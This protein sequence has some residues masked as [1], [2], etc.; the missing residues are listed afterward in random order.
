MIRTFTKGLV[1]GAL[2]AALA[3]ALIG[4]A[5]PAAADGLQVSLDAKG[6]NRPSGG[7]GGGGGGGGGGGTVTPAYYDWMAANVE[8]AWALGALGSGVTITVVDDY[9]S[10]DVFEGRLVSADVLL[11][12]HGQWTS[13]QAGLVAPGATVVQRDWT[14]G[15]PVKL[16]GGFNVINLSYGVLATAGLNVNNLLWS[17][18]DASIIAAAENGDALISK[19]AGNTWGL[20]VGEAFT[21]NGALVQD[22]LALDLIGAQSALFVGALEWNPDGAGPEGMASYSTIAGTDA[23]VQAQFLVV[24]VEGGRLLGDEFANYGIACGSTEGTCL[25]GTSFAAPIVSGYGALVAS[26]FTSATPTQVA[27]QLLGTTDRDTLVDIGPA[28]WGPEDMAVYGQGEA[29]VFRA[30]APNSLN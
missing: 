7:D 28:G 2:G 11:Q 22:Y 20:A 15:G 21:S 4:L 9:N 25:Y 12:T 16:G 10:G 13:Q 24:G 3:A 8:D 14:G 23:A 1:T 5:V 26:K 27:Q 18:R 17:R 30:V 19:S 29:N 6:G